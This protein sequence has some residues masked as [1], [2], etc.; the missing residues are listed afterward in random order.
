MLGDGD[1]SVAEVRAQLP[2]E[3]IV[4][5][6]GCAKNRALYELPEETAQRRGQTTSADEGASTVKGRK[7]PRNGWSSAEAG[8]KPTLQLEDA[9]SAPATGWRDHS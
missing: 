3:G 9:R 8:V 5:M 4:L 2:E 7:S 1:F 6:S